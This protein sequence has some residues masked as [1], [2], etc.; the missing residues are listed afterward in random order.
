ML[1]YNLFRPAQPSL[2]PPAVTQLHIGNTQPLSSLAAEHV[3]SRIAYLK[4]YLKDC[5]PTLSEEIK[6][7]VK[8][9]FHQYLSIQQL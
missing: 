4:K 9:L 2:P 5:H 7:S 3:N 1:I 8:L 6:R